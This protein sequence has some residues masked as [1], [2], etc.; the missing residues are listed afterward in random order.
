M[1]RGHASV[2]GGASRSLAPKRVV[3]RAIPQRNGALLLGSSA[4]IAWMLART[5]SG[6]FRGELKAL[7]A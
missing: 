6:V 5:L 3:D 2:D 7:I 4:V 1:D